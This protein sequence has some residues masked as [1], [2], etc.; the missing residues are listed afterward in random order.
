M[1]AVEGAESLLARIRSGGVDTE[2]D[3]HGIPYQDV[4]CTGKALHA[5]VGGSIGPKDCRECVQAL[6]DAKADANTEAT[7]SDKTL[8]VQALHMAAYAGHFRVIGDLVHAKAHVDMPETVLKGETSTF[9]NTPLH[10]AIW[11]GEQATAL[12]LLR[13][14]ADA[15]IENQGFT[16]LHHAA[17]CGNDRIVARMLELADDPRCLAQLRSRHRNRSALLLA[18]EAGSVRSFEHLLKHS[19]EDDLR[20]CLDFAIQNQPQILSALLES[21]PGL[22]LKEAQDAAAMAA[23]IIGKVGS[24]WAKVLDK[25]V[26]S[27]RSLVA[28]LA[29]DPRLSRYESKNMMVFWQ[30]DFKN[31]WHGMACLTGS[32]RTVRFSSEVLSFGAKSDMQ[33]KHDLLQR[34]KQ[35]EDSDQAPQAVCLRVLPYDANDLATVELM[36]A[37]VAT[38]NHEMM[39]TQFVSAVLADA[40]SRIWPWYY[41]HAGIA[42]LQVIFMCLS[43][44]SLSY[45]PPDSFFVAVLLFGVVKRGIEEV[46]RA[47]LLVKRLL[48]KMKEFR[49]KTQERRSLFGKLGRQEFL[50]VML[51]VPLDWAYLAFSCVGLGRLWDFRDPDPGAKVW[52]ATYVTL[53]WLSFLYWLRGLELWGFNRKLLPIL[54]AMQG[55][56]TVLMVVALTF[57]AAAHSYYILGQGRMSNDGYDAY[58]AFERTFRL[59]LLGDFDLTELEFLDSVLS[60]ESSLC[61]S[62]A[63]ALTEEDPEPTADYIPIRLFFY[64]VAVG[65]SV[66]EMNLFIGVLGN[67][68]D[69]IAKDSARLV[70][71]ERARLVVFIHQNPFFLLYHALCPGC[72]QSKDSKVHSASKGRSEESKLQPAIP[73]RRDGDKD[74]HGDAGRR[75]CWRNAEED[76][77]AECEWLFAVFRDAEGDRDEPEQDGLPEDLSDDLS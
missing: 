33:R 43:T 49:G 59:G 30:L 52:V 74:E 73:A 41:W 46:W 48:A 34:L 2:E 40:W 29:E 38:R 42:L 75:G 64:L 72:R 58:R 24:S 11:Y 39:D 7:S 25:L 4:F 53:V 14:K 19:R 35:Y 71:R 69:E 47:M 45:G 65:I 54:R 28:R 55:S 18:A 12:E 26:W 17:R 67:A 10:I 60:G 56:G 62:D 9:R 76:K 37:I 27:P 68:Y 70:T 3:F 16:V 31:H 22:V 23:Q 63:P 5:A 13:A 61:A 57:C 8:K 44:W 36:Q 32:V 6:L 15:S 1:T 51:D 66:V 21:A 50:D 77:R 20:A